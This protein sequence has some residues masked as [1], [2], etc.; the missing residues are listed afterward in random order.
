MSEEN[1]GFRVIH[2]STLNIFIASQSPHS[3]NNGYFSFENKNLQPNW[4]ILLYNY[5]MPGKKLVEVMI[6]L[7]E[8][9]E[10][11][12]TYVNLN[13]KEKYFLMMEMDN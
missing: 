3:F 6:H 1:C 7:A 2:T 8:D 10:G 12:A 13:V 5:E 11:L 9:G 4:I